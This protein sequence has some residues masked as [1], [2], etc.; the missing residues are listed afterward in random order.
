[1]LTTEELKEK[2]NEITNE[3]LC[4]GI[5]DE[6]LIN[7]AKGAWDE[8][9]GFDL[10]ETKDPEWKFWWSLLAFRYANLRMRRIDGLEDLQVADKLFQL[11]SATFGKA[12]EITS[13]TYLASIYRL[14]VLSRLN[15]LQPKE[16]NYK[17]EIQNLWKTLMSK[18]SDYEFDS[19]KRAERVKYPFETAFH[20]LLELSSYF[21]GLEAHELHGKHTFYSL[22]FFETNQS[23]RILHSKNKNSGIRYPKK[24]AIEI[25]LSDP[26]AIVYQLDSIEISSDSKED[27]KHKKDSSEEEKALD[28]R[29]FPSVKKREWLAL[30]NKAH[31]QSANP[32]KEHSLEYLTWILYQFK[33]ERLPDDDNSRH[34]KGRLKKCLVEWSGYNIPFDTSRGETTRIN[35]DMKTPI[36]GVVHESVLKNIYQYKPKKSTN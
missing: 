33:K 2:V 28:P 14:S 36:I 30:P 9:G 16:E 11:N 34:V 7:K 8:A 29:I 4:Q 18:K 27:A 3:K 32:P 35:S 23:Y 31:L 6:S 21:L 5:S 10:P 25:A 13:I 20:N 17:K 22:P 24:I 15:T 1:M 12:S 19:N 26:N